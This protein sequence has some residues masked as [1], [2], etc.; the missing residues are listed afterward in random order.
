MNDILEP[1]EIDALMHEM[2]GSD[3]PA[4]QAADGR[5]RYDFATQD[6][7]V[8]RLIPALSLVQTQFSEALKQRLRQLSPDIQ[9]VRAERIAVMKFGELQ[10]MLTP[11]CDISVI[12]A[13]PLGAPIYL[14]FEADLVFALVDQFFGGRGGAGIKR[15]QSDFSPSEARFMQ[16]LGRALLP[17]LGQAWHSVVEIVPE[18]LERHSDLRFVDHLK[19]SDNLL[20]ARFAVTMPG[21][22][23][24]VWMLV[25]WAAIDP[26]RE[27]L[28]G[29]SQGRASRQEHDEQWRQRLLQGI[30]ATSLNV[31]ARLNES[32]MPLSRVSRLAVGDV[33]PID[34]PQGVTLLIEELALMTGTFGTHQGQLAVKV[35]HQLN[36]ILRRA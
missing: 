26:V 12:L 15:L 28:G 20:A 24:G 14:V 29:Q 33:L 21:H 9:G 1:A 31:V 32:A 6:Y 23:C 19:Q 22:D 11:P 17:D 16:Q 27:H 35:N 2:R 36:P 30:E 10:R 8:Q 25:P 3:A 18:L 7:A 5:D 4:P 34:S 13:T